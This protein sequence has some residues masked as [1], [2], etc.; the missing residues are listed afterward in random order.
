MVAK[1]Q[2]RKA[3]SHVCIKTFGEN[4]HRSVHVMKQL[5]VVLQRGG[6]KDIRAVPQ[7]EGIHVSPV[8]QAGCPHFSLHNDKHV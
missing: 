2:W 3:C 6:S 4:C 7:T 8:N 1:V 5:L